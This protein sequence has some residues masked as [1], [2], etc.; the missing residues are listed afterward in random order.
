MRIVVAI[1]L[2]VLVSTGA[3][4]QGRGDVL[5]KSDTN[6]DGQ[7]TREEFVA[8]RAER[9]DRLDRNGDGFIDEADL[10]RRLARR[11]E[12]LG[13]QADRDGDGKVNRE[14]FVSA[15]TVAFDA[16]DLDGNDVLDAKEVESAREKMK[17]RAA[18]RRG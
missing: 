5:A 6:Q 16:A 18:E 2:V 8:A 1:S 12:E 14:E 15:P 9:F 10:P 7:I 4:A 3:L 17:K 13:A 11:Y